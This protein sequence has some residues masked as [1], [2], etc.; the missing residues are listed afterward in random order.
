MPL[1]RLVGDALFFFREA[2]DGIELEFV[3][4]R[5]SAP[6][7]SDNKSLAYKRLS[8]ISTTEYTAFD[9]MG[10]V[11][12][13]R[14]TTDGLSYGTGYVYNLAGALTEETYSSGRVVK[15]LLDNNGDLSIVE[16]RKNQT[17]G[18]FSYAKNFTYNASGELTSMQ[19]GCSRNFDLVIS[20]VLLSSSYY[21]P[22]PLLC[23]VIF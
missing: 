11:T 9:M 12:A 23:L 7:F 16:S 21:R 13:S 1:R 4:V 10:R 20:P 14:Q 22:E 17:A 15:N 18:F 5:R 8:S 6:S 3:I 19:L 2:G